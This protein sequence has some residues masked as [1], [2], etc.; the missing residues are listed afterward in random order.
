VIRLI[1]QT[2]ADVENDMNSVERLHYYSHGLEQEPVNTTPQIVRNTWPVKG[3]LQFKDVK[4]RYRP[5]LPLVLKAL[6]VSICSGE[7][8]G[9]VGRTGAGKASIISIIFRLV[10]LSHGSITIDGMNIAA[11]SLY[12]LR[13]RLSIIPQDPTLFQGTIRTNLD[14]IDEYENNRLWDALR[15][16]ELVGDKV[17]TAEGQATTRISLDSPVEDESLN[18]SLGQRQ[19]LALS[20]IL[21][22]DS[23]I[24][25]I[26]EATSSVDFETDRKVQDTILRAFR[27]K[28]LLC[29][30]HRIKTIIG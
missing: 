22:K 26:D 27:T 14:P 12:D 7:R 17:S 10:E 11:L 1:V 13:P 4:M 16:G 29:I 21:I 18:Y 3:E 9:I 23:Q 28:T 24:I 2:Y 5:G 15:K 30:A 20:R 6:S 19:L 8:V 25:M